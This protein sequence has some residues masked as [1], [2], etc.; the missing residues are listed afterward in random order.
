M[1]AL[2]TVGEGVPYKNINSVI[3]D[4]NNKFWEDFVSYHIVNHI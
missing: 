3:R 2:E 4:S 1:H